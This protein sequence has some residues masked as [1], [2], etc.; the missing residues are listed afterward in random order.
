MS[1]Q[2][3]IIICTFSRAPL[4]R[5][6]LM[7]LQAV[8]G[9]EKAEVIV[10]DNNSKDDTEEVVYACMDALRGKVNLRYV[11][12]PCQGLSVARNTGILSTTSDIVAFLDDDAIPVRG[13]IT[14]IL[15]AFYTHLDVDAIG[16]IVH[17]NFEVERPAW[18]IK[19]FELPFTIVH[20]G[21]EMRPYPKGQHPVGAN[22]AFRRDVF[23]HI[24]FPEH[25]GRKGASLI[26]GEE[27]WLFEQMKK[28]RK[29]ILYV[30]GMAVY[31][32]I[33]R[34]RLT[35]NWIA[36]RYYFQGVSYSMSARTLLSKLKLLAKT[37][38]KWAY[39]FVQSRFSHSEGEKLLVDCRH[40][41]IR[42]TLWTLKQTKRSSQHG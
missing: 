4:L 18:L 9:I 13:W 32:F 21:T 27:S 19:P 23:K 16:G 40:E 37:Y 30:P 31:H 6:T 36:E 42:G 22:M 38:M 11:L 5:K 35:K 39:I 7:A 20:L 14:S 33:P 34:S 2:V 29:K 41:S 26:S 24:E 25:L 15:H 28:E 17:P 1:I 3:S 10:V 12:E 8:E